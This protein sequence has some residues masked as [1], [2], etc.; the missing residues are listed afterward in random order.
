MS[1]KCW[2][3]ICAVNVGIDAKATFESIASVYIY[4]LQ[5]TTLQDLNVLTDV[6]RETVTDHAHE[7]PLEYG[8][9]WGMI[10]NSNVKVCLG[11]LCPL[12]SDLM[13]ILFE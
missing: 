11:L 12:W 8:K 4:S 1:E 6:A 7:D 10:Q 5:P 9:Q 3:G 13:R 2:E